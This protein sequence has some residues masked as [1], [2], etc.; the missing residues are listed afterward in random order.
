LTL[1][2]KVLRS[3]NQSLIVNHFS[4]YFGKIPFY[5]ACEKDKSTVDISTSK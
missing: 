2:T 3:L 5:L 1:L 4:E